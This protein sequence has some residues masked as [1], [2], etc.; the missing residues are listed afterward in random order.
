MEK[1]WDLF[2]QSVIIQ[3]MVT[4]ILIVTI[5][6]MAINNQIIPPFIQDTTALVIGFWFGSK[7]AYQR[8]IEKRQNVT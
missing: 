4:L 3:G 6:I 1:F 5:C 7:I 8:A 2:K